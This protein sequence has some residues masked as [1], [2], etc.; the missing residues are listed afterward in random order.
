MIELELDGRTVRFD[1]TG[2]DPD[3]PDVIYGSLR[4]GAFYEYTFL[5]YVR[6]LG[7]QGVY[8]D[9]GA[10][11]G[12]H[13]VFFAMFCR[14]TRVHAFEAQPVF[15]TRLVTNTGLNG[16]ADDVR[17]HRVALSD[18]SGGE[19]TLTFDEETA[20]AP[21]QRLDDLVDEPVAVIKIDVEGMEPQVIAGARRTI[22]RSHPVVFAEA[23]TP[24]EYVAMCAELRRVGYRW[25]G[26]VF[27]ASPTYEFV[28]VP[29]QRRAL[30]TPAGRGLQARAPAAAR[31]LL[32][33]LV[34]PGPDHV[35]DR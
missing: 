4:K 30:D 9:V 14:A 2:I 16:L 17:T 8:V 12:T 15:H 23:R 13:T 5:H 35:A 29:W 1:D 34:P 7:L 18:R 33:R 21:V 19:V 11:V 22:R 26:R 28:H 24:A 27:N 32:L 25:T 10:Y 31:A 3:V 6:S 20:V